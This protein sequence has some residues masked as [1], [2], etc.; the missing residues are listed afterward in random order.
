MVHVPF[1]KTEAHGI[2]CAAMFIDYNTIY[3]GASNDILTALIK[4]DMSSAMRLAVIKLAN[5]KQDHERHDRAEVVA[6]SEIRVMAEAILE[7]A[8]TCDDDDPDLY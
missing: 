5:Y 4:K 8:M 1:S 2:L 6:D 7:D 3:D